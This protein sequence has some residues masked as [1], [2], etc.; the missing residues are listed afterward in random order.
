MGSA[1]V[2]HEACKCIRMHGAGCAGVWCGDV[3]KLGA[4]GW[5]PQGGWFDIFVWRSTA[6]HEG[7]GRQGAA[8]AELL[9]EERWL[10]LLRSTAPN[11]AQPWLCPHVVLLGP[12]CAPLHTVKCFCPCC[13]PVLLHPISSTC[14]LHFPNATM[15]SRAWCPAGH[16][17]VWWEGLVESQ[18]SVAPASLSI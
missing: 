2:P 6:M 15:L 17:Q 7:V 8:G 16:I 4:T 12:C 18:W 14:L 9:Q 11:P 1:Q 5:E 3:A 13:H 10:Q